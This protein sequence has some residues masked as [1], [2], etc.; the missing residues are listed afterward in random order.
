MLDLALS[1]GQ[2]EILLDW[3]YARLRELETSIPNSARLVTRKYEDL[4]VAA[5]DRKPSRRMGMKARTCAQ[6]DFYR[7]VRSICN[8]SYVELAGLRPRSILSVDSFLNR[9]LCRM[10]KGVWLHPPGSFTFHPLKVDE[11]AN[12]W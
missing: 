5:K 11:I 7:T 8:R 9:A 6:L 4:Y 12:L 10:N 3:W 2:Y 1:A